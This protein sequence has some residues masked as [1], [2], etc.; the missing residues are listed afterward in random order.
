MTYDHPLLVDLYDE[1][2][3][4]GADHQFY[5]DLID[6]EERRASRQGS[7]RGSASGMNSRSPF[8]IVD[9]GCGTGLLTATLG[10]AGER[11]R[12]PGGAEA[13]AA[14]P[15]RVIGI[16]PS[17]EMLTR[18][19]VRTGVSGS[20][21]GSR[22]LAQ[23]GA[24][25][26]TAEGAATA[27]EVAPIEWVHGDADALCAQFPKPGDGMD[28]AIMTGNVA[29]HLIGEE[30]TSA[31]SALAGHIH[32]GGVLAF[33]SRNPTLR[34]WEAWIDGPPTRRQTRHGGLVESCEL[35]EVS[36]SGSGM[37]TE[38]GYPDTLVSLRFHN[39]FTDLGRELAEDLALAFRTRESI[40]AALTTVGF[41][42]E[43]VAGNWNAKP[44]EATDPIMIF[45]ARRL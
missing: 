27:P 29:Q 39:T 16:D 41:T 22:D 9:L 40:E 35:L 6:S 18:A 44:F 36:R 25:D 15:R 4:D 8:T 10:S 37:E 31:L 24:G 5:R 3:P 21:V 42:I 17:A 32:P 1:D 11:G 34:A 20:A 43:S 12:T 45:T 7:R 26:S 14:L 38:H 33:E 19:R 30:W 2:N 28:V 13:V 23:P